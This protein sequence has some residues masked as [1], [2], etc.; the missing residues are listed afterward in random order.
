MKPVFQSA[1]IIGCL[2]TGLMMTVHAEEF[3]RTR[4]KLAA[5]EPVK[6]VCLGDSVTGIYYH[7]GGLRAYP[8]MIGVGMK[9][10]DP[11]SKVTVVNSGISGHSTANGLERFQKDVLDHKPDLVTVMFG[12]NDIVRVPQPDFEANLKTFIEKNREI[13]AETLLCTPNGIYPT[14]GRP[15]EKLEEYNQAM[16]AVAEANGAGFCDVYA[17]YQAVKAKNEL[18]FRLLCSDP[19]HPNMDGHKLNAETIIQSITGKKISLKDVGPP[20]P[21]LAKTK[22]LIAEKQPVRVYA[23]TPFDEWIGPALQAKYPD[24]QLEIAAWP[25][26]DK[27]LA[28]L[29][30]AAKE[31]RGRN[32][33]PDLVVVAIPL[34]VTPPLSQPPEAGIENHSWTLNFALS[35]G[36][37]DWDVLAVTPSVLK[38]ELTAAEQ[39]R[40]AFSRRMIFAQDLPLITRPAGSTDDAKTILTKWLAK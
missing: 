37:Q 7:T 24:A 11:Q 28:E 30:E 34:E 13:G 29:H 18:D 19:F 9:L 21:V 27:S 1:W 23:M 5:H 3:P 33:K 32:P 14:P 26:K 17:A 31:V 4:A 39:D 10:L 2:A 22:R 20:E 35:F 38:P 25:T 12:L 16:K 36:V 6:I 15:V 8:E 40:D